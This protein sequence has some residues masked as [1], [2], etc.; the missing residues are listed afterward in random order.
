MYMSSEIAPTDI[1]ISPKMSVVFYK[2]N[3]RLCI[4]T[5]LQDSGIILQKCCEIS[6]IQNVTDVLLD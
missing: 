6:Q 1:L 5:E 4:K 2:M 3:F